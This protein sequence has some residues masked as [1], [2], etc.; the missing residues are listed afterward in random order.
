MSL[1]GIVK[2][3]KIE[4]IAGKNKGTTG[5]VVKVLPKKNAVLV[6]GVGAGHRH[7][8]PNQLNPRG[9][10][11]DIHVATPVHKVKKIEAAKSAKKSSKKGD[12]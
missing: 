7:V 6:E 12:K 8:K 9:G 2:G 3:D 1:S 5:E 10:V 4:I 11:K